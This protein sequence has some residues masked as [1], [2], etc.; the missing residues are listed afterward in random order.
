MTD[1]CPP[2]NLPEVEH[3]VELADGRVLGYAEFGDRAGLP[4]LWFHGTPGAS[5]Q[6]PPEAPTVARDRGIRLIGLERPGTGRS[7]AHQYGR[8]L[9][10]A[11][12]VR[13]VSDRLG[14][15][16]FAVVGLS[17]GGPFVLACA[18]LMPDRVVAGAVLGGIGPTVGPEA[19]PGYTRLLAPFAPLL[20]LVA[21]PAGLAMTWLLRPLA[22]VAASPLFDLYARLGP[23][24]DRSVLAQ[25]E[26]KAAFL[27]DLTTAIPHGL[28]APV[29]D[30]VLFARH[31]GFSLR[32]VQVPIRFWHGADDIVVP[33]SHGVHQAELVP[34]AQLTVVPGGGHFAGYE[35]VHE[36]FDTLLLLWR[37][38]VHRHRRE[39]SA[40]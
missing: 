1:P 35:T 25:P 32:D 30:L 10:W 28:R 3:V 37:G 16:R 20:S 7:S 24:P 13:Q 5:K 39:G 14:L 26:M 4:V 36:V 23:G 21:G 40:V 11:L 17:G 2:P 34:D 29:Y 8:V 27:H 9:D 6:V 31:W 19:A 12:D 15:E 38:E 33:L 18:Y 22:A